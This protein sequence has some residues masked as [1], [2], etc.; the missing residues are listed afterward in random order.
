MCV[1]LDR[2]FF[3][4]YFVL[5]SFYDITIPMRITTTQSVTNWGYAIGQGTKTTIDKC[6]RSHLECLISI[7]LF[8]I[9]KNVFLDVQCTNVVY[10]HRVFLCHTMRYL[11]IYANK[12][13]FFPRFIFSGLIVAE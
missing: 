6:F 5:L 13:I 11:Y 12:N 2:G 9:S 4:Y 8:L 1:L 3:Y 7:C 10:L